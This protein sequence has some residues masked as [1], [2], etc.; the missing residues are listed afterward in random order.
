MQ[1]YIEQ[2]GG[3]AQALVLK[4]GIRGFVKTFGGHLMDAYDEKAW[5][6]AD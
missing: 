3:E 5:E 6:R 1:D 2:V 4:G